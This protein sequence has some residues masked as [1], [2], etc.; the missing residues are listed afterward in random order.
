M[1]ICDGG[2][3]YVPRIF[4]HKRTLII[5]YCVSL[6]VAEE[7]KSLLF[8][9]HSRNVFLL[10]PLEGDT[11]PREEIVGAEALSYASPAHD[12]RECDTRARVASRTYG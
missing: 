4:R 6:Y 3:Y 5:I 9:S 1:P 2:L 12:I 8:F 11:G 7:V 10:F